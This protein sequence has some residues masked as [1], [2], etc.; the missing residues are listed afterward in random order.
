MGTEKKISP[1]AAWLEAG[2]SILEEQGP[3]SLSIENLAAGTGKTKGSFYHHF[4][5][6]E[7]YIE[8]LLAHYGEM[9]E[10]HIEESD[11]RQRLKK[12]TEQVFQISSRLELV[13]RAWSL[14]DPKVKAFQDEM[15][16][17]RLDFLR[18]LYASSM[19]DEALV[20]FTVYKNYSLFIGLQQIRHLYE[21]RQFKDLL[22][23]IFV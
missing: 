16:R 8:A 22:R 2:L 18:G 13:I 7:D 6:R 14:Y 11:H 19:E 10:A 21:G 5:N 17:K 15:D 9:T 23:G 3:A 12:L 4:K 1:R 20:E